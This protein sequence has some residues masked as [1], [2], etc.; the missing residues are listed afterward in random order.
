MENL[1]ENQALYVKSMQLWFKQMAGLIESNAHDVSNHKWK[2]DF[3][4]KQLTLDQE[5][6]ENAILRLEKGKADF[7]NWCQDNEFEAEQFN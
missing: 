3:Y 2:A 5:A 1:T 7:K 6:L 4:T